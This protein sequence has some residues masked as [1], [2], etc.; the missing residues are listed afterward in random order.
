VARLLQSCLNI[1][2]PA[3]FRR[4]LA[5][6]NPVMILSF[7]LLSFACSTGDSPVEPVG[8]SSA[9]QA[10]DATVAEISLPPTTESPDAQAI[11]ISEGTL[12]DMAPPSIVADTFIHVRSGENLVGLSGWAQTTPTELAH[13]NGMEVQDTLFAGQA[14]G[15]TLAGEALDHFEEQ[16]EIAFENR[17][18]GYLENR[19]GLYTV[20]GHAMR[21]GETVWGIARDN[22]GLPMWVVSAFNEDLNLDRLAIGDI[23]TLPV[24]AD[25]VQVS[26]EPEVIAPF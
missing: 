7:S 22:G 15:F 4:R 24:L 8:V 6:R 25:S 20:D 1:R 11:T 16:R 21:S 23:V 10:P 13:L 19:G 3:V 17:L 26:V 2:N 12:V 9:G 18:E 5:M 14:L